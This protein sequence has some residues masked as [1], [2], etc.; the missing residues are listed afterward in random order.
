MASGRDDDWDSF[1]WETWGE[2]P[3][4]DGPGGA[5]GHIPARASDGDEAGESLEEERRGEGKWVSQGGILRWVTPGDDDEEEDTSPRAEVNSP[6]ADEEV[7]LPPGAPDTVRIRAARAWLLRQRALE[8]E[9]QG[10]LLL[11]RRRLQ[12]PQDEDES[13]TARRGPPEDSPLD[14]ALAEHQAAL[15]EYERLVEEL[16]EIANHSGPARVLVEYHLYLTE[17]LAELATAP[18]APAEFAEQLLLVPV[19]DEESAAAPRGPASPRAEAE[20]RGRAEAV[21]ATRRRVEKVSVPEP[22]D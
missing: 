20:W 1:D 16:A 22:E 15:E 12:G 19:E 9:A 10:A 2:A 13:P 7:D 8:A 21:V 11:E 3:S 17:R 4:A 5:N 18:E 14:I 6:W